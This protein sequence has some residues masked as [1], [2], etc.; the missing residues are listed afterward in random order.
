MSMTNCHFCDGIELKDLSRLTELIVI[1]PENECRYSCRPCIET[2]TSICA[3]CGEI[4]YGADGA[5]C[6]VCDEEDYYEGNSS[7]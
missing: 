2:F 6:P 5:I 3:A 1:Y 7:F 4:F